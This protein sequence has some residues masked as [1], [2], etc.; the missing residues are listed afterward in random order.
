MPEKPNIN[1]C[2]IADRFRFQQ[3]LRRAKTPAEQQSLAAKICRS[4]CKAEARRKNLPEISYPPELPVSDKADEIT[5]LIQ[6]HRVLIVAGETGSGKSTQLPK[7]CLAAGQGIF[8]QIAHTQPRRIA[9]RAI[10]A[11]LAEELNLELGAGIGYRVRFDERCSS[12]DYIRVLTDGMLLAEAQTDSFLNQ[13]DTI[14]ID[15]AHERSLN[16]DFLLGILKQLLGRRKDL[17][18]IITSA[19]IDTEKFARHFSDAPI[20]NVS[21]RTYPVEV[22]Y[23]P[24]E[25]EKTRSDQ[26]TNQAILDAIQKLFRRHPGNTL[27]FLPG[28]REIREAQR[29]LERQLKSGI[30]VLPLYARLAREQQMR[31]FR[32]SHN[33]RI[34]LSTNVAETSLTLPGIDYVIDTG[35]ARISRYNP[36]RRVNT[37]PIERIS[38]AA[39]DQRKG[40]CGRV[41][42][43]ICV[44]LFSEEDFLSREDYTAPEILRTALTGV[45]LSLKSRR[46]GEPEAFPFIDPPERKQWNAAHQEL[47]ILGALTPG[48]GLSRIGRALAKL[49]VDPR[50]G[51]MLYAA[52][53]AENCLAEMT[54]LAASLE[55]Q[56]PRI[57]PFEKLQAARQHHIEQ[58]KGSCDFVALLELYKQFQLQ[59]AKLSRKQLN[60]WCQKNYLAPTRMR[61]WQDLVKRLRQ[62]MSLFKFPINKQPATQ[63]AIHRA[64]LCGLLDQVAMKSDK[65]R[66][67]GTYGKQLA[68]FPGSAL[69]KTAP[70]WI[71]AAEMVE[72]SQLFAR[73]V[74][75]AK[76]GW[77]EEFAGP[78][79]RHE[80]SEPHWSLKAGQVMAFQR[81]Y[82]LNLPIFS[83]RR[84]PYSEVDPLES[85]ALFIRE[86]L[87]PGEFE[88][89]FDFVQHNLE[90]LDQVVRLEHKIRRHDILVSEQT[91]ANFYAQNLPENILSESSLKKWLKSCSKEAREKL[92]LTRAELLKRELSKNELDLPDELD[93]GDHRLSL[94]YHFS[95]GESNDGISA[96]IPLPLLNQLSQADFDKLVP[97]YLPEKI[98]HLI[99]SLPKAQRKQLVPIPDTVAYANQQLK[100]DARPLLEALAGLLSQRSGQRISTGDFD[101]KTLPAHLS[102]KLVLLDEE[103][104]ELGRAD[105]VDALQ[106]HYGQQA[107]DTIAQADHAWQKTGYTR[108][109]FEDLPDSVELGSHGLTTQA[110][111]ALVDATSCVNIQLFD[112]PEHARL[113]HQAGV[114]RLVHLGTEFGKKLAKR[115]L[116]YWQEI[117]L[118]YSP[119]GSQHD[120]RAALLDAVTL[121]LM[122]EKN[123][124]LRSKATFDQAV[125]H[126]AQKFSSVIEPYCKALMQALSAYGETLST[127]DSLNL[128]A[129]SEQDIH[130]QLNYLIYED[131][132]IEVPLAILRHYP[133][134]FKALEAR[135]ER[136]S[137]DPQGDLKKLSL[138]LPYQNRYLQ[139]WEAH[140]HNAELDTYRWQLEAYRVSLFAPKLKPPVPISPTRLE[141]T[142]RVFKE[143][144]LS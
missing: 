96:R 52:G 86:G 98:E 75:P 16:I 112:D 14:I 113:A 100:D 105:S 58:A 64:L 88:Q 82:F 41:K 104:D 10:S 125:A 2:L 74:A 50:I 43:G 15:E 31:L 63:E 30:D 102:M 79:V 142:W 140:P 80:Y 87:V 42:E 138:L 17:K 59:R 95:P 128:P 111:P 70:K 46:L 85:R 11:R 36:G 6:R 110:C 106:Q 37:L 61:E 136:I 67:T 93:H 7:L 28:E 32:P 12:T 19:T 127:L 103:G 108:W 45:V 73:S 141:R 47:K 118:R 53:E 34:I 55:I 117:S 90:Q 94:D 131:F 3:Q 115:P 132:L 101:T 8:G 25:D 81:G 107:R 89:R 39:A 40:R 62:D 29:F 71:M 139:N 20:I 1:Q 97:G 66:Y 120:L 77:I 84:R 18:L 116:P 38:K 130:T 78:L 21:G 60:T 134:Y 124:P 51:R 109:D 49:S 122:F 133:T 69:A 119:I 68:L 99:R 54:I 114:T 76:V 48:N 44:R 72:T 137:Y 22:L 56:D 129:E 57:T 123:D 92:Y 33:T 143:M 126:L 135:L 9:A 4:I 83:G 5:R 27:V 35:L 13:Y 65:G 144:H 23:Q 121:E 24:P 26:Q 91:L